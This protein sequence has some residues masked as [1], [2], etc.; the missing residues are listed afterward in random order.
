MDGL[1]E[2]F[3]ALAVSSVG[4][5]AFAGVYLIGGVASAF[6]LPDTPDEISRIAD[7][8]AVLGGA[9]YSFF[10]PPGNM[11]VI[12]ANPLFHADV[13]PDVQAVRLFNF[14]LS[15]PPILWLLLRC[16][17]PLAL[18]VA[19]VAMPFMWLVTAT[20]SQQ[21]LMLALLVVLLQSALDGRRAALV[22]AAAGLYFV[23]PAMLPVI[24]GGFFLAALLGQPMPHAARAALLGVIPF[25]A[26]VA[27]V[28]IL[29]GDLRPTLSG[30]GASNLW[31]GN[32]PD[33]LSHRGVA[34]RPLPSDLLAA[35]FEFMRQET[36][37]FV[38]NLLRKITLYWVPWDYMRSGLGG[39]LQAVFFGYVAV[40]QATIY[41]TAIALR[42]SVRP[43]AL[44][45]AIA[46]AL[47]AWALY[48][49][50]FVKIRFRVPFDLLI[51][52]AVMMPRRDRTA[53]ANDGPEPPSA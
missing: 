34:T 41:A 52:A 42:H 16:R 6:A 37:A 5:R 35:T 28:W 7:I 20:A 49:L 10:W 44:T 29:T 19:L 9:S 1:L 32:N 40:V 25:A 17:V 12:L 45:T 27:F 2:R 47:L 26:V 33:P 14:L 51:L 48:S 46:I 39:D 23:N 13:L 30:N 53:R 43:G 4:R 11:A 3:S 50:F 38:M 18:G 31:L 36:L 15:A 8:R 21:G 24:P 22:A